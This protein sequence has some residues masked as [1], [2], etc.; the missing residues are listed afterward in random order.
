MET[1]IKVVTIAGSIYGASGLIGVLMGYNQFQSGTKHDDPM[2]AEKG[3]QTMLWGGASA[4]I[5][6][7]V[8]VACVAALR[9][10]TF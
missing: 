9:G 3:A 10:I 2:K 7:G 6:A 1:V 4:A 5:A 8:V